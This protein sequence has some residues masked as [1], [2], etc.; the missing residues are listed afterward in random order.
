MRGCD[1]ALV[2]SVCV[3]ANFRIIPRLVHQL[4][5]DVPQVRVSARRPRK[6]IF[7]SRMSGH[8]LE[9][10][11]NGAVRVALKSNGTTPS[12]DGPGGRPPA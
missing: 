1:N 6:G 5:S 8:V 7:L 3:N 2:E 12:H 11:D 9:R 4:G 10:S